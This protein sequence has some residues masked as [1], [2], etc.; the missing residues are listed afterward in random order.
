MEIKGIDVSKWQGK[1]DWKAVAGS[2]VKFAMIRTAYGS[3][4]GRITIDPYFAEN[5]RGAVAAGIRVGVYLYSY[6]RTVYA[7]RLEAQNLVAALAASKELITYPVAYDLE[8]ASQQSLG[9]VRNGEMVRA[10][11][12]VVRGAGY[13]PILYANKSWIDNHI[14]V[15]DD[16]SV[17][18]ARWGVSDPGMPCQ[19]WQY[20]DSGRVAGIKGNVDLNISYVDYAAPD[21]RQQVKARFGFEESTMD[22]LAAYKY[23][24]DLL[25]K[26]A[27]AP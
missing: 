25:R 11:C 4:S 21:Y 6:A 12:D 8:D 14:D 10:F 5:V 20:S 7:A 17:W 15:P 1:I 13:Q 23:G 27:T 2:G 9:R 16:V 24:A 3:T 18:L 26:L 22:Y 19:M